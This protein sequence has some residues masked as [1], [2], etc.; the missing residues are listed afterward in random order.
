MTAW[1]SWRSV[2][3]EHGLVE[4]R[5]LCGDLGQSPD[6]REITVDRRRVDGDN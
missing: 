4:F 2:C 6:V 1:T 3:D 5:S